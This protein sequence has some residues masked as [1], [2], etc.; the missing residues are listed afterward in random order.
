MVSSIVEH[1]TR[2]QRTK[3]CRTKDALPIPYA[4]YPNSLPTSYPRGTLVALARRAA[5]RLFRRVSAI[6]FY[7]RLSR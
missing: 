4:S 6:K 7:V 1:W 2:D 5:R 3:T